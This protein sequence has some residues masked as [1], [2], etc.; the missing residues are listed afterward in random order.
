MR[1]AMTI[2]LFC[3]SILSFGQSLQDT[4]LRELTPIDVQSNKNLKL[5][6]GSFTVSDG[7][8]GYTYRLDTS[9][10]FERIEFADIGGSEVSAKGKVRVTT[11][12]RLDLRSEKGHSTFDVFAFATFFFLIPPA[13]VPAFK[14]DFSKA[15]SIFGKQRI[16]KVG[17]ESK[18]VYLMIAFSLVSRYLVK[19]IE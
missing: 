8:G 9:G 19:G 3:I 6:A 15:V 18:T 16:Y 13:K 10:A 2:M 1:I 11:N 14:R 7:F 4:L 12:H 5:L 17:D